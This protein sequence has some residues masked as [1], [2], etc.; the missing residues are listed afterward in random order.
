MNGRALK[1]RNTFLPTP[2]PPLHSPIQERGKE[3]LSC[4][5]SLFLF[6]VLLGNGRAKKAVSTFLSTPL[7]IHLTAPLTPGKEFFSSFSSLFLLLVLPVNG[8][9]NKFVILPT[10]L[11]SFMCMLY[12]SLTFLLRVF[13]QCVCVFPP[14]CYLFL[15]CMKFSF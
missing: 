14:D 3:L 2:P 5:S 8:R 4:C 6:L 12:V 10:I 11:F 15:T 9:A 7:P 13:C 1:A